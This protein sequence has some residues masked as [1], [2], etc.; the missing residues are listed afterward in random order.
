MTET[1]PTAF[2]VDP[3]DAWERIGSVGKPQLLCSARIVDGDGREVAGRRGRRP[4][5]RRAR[6]DA[7]LLAQRGGDPRRLHRRR[8]AASRATSPA[9]TPTASSGSP[10][11][12]R[13]CSSRAART[14]IRPRSRMCSPPIRRSST[15]RCSPRRT[16]N[17]ARSAAP[18][19][20][21][22]RTA[23]RPDGAELDRLLP[24]PPRPLQ[25]AE[26]LRV[27]RRIPAHLGRQDP[28]ASA[29]SGTVKPRAA[30]LEI[31][32]GPAAAGPDQK[33]TGWDMLNGRGVYSAFARALWEIR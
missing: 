32:P 20:S 9:A 19:S 15:P 2:L 17:G 14:S 12:G 30:G 16:R 4:A 29:A 21:S 33:P 27:R 10:G 13:R 7:R 24:R 1:G 8:L 5:V 31:R 18:S 3:A 25:G 11:G 26:A 23:A 22:R 28:E 6:R